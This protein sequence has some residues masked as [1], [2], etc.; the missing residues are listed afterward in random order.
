MQGKVVGFEIDCAG[1][2]IDTDNLCRI[3]PYNV[4]RATHSQSLLNGATTNVQ[5][6]FD[7][8]VGRRLVIGY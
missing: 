6:K 2:R 4:T 8:A 7:A 1:L 5:T 3:N